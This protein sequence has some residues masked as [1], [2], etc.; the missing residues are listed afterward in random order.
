M[1]TTYVI[2]GIF[3][4]FTLVRSKDMPQLIFSRSFQFTKF[5]K[6]ETDSVTGAELF[7]REFLGHPKGN[8][9]N[10][11]KSYTRHQYTFLTKGSINLIYLCKR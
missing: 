9:Y 8:T 4:N 3:L 7:R 2:T 6:I 5:W 11:F 10:Y 1:A